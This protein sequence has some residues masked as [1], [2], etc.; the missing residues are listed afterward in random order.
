MPVNELQKG[1]QTKLAISI[2]IGTVL[3][4]I[5]LLAYAMDAVQHGPTWE[6]PAQAATAFFFA[7]VIS[8]ILNLIGTIMY[9][10]KQNFRAWPTTARSGFCAFLIVSI[11]CWIVLL[12]SDPGQWPIRSPRLSVGVRAVSWPVIIACGIFWLLSLALGDRLASGETKQ[13][14]RTEDRR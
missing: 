2:G 12:I 13:V 11:A 10:R 6:V 1:M 5:A 4:A 14:A 7:M 9:F 3:G 8:P